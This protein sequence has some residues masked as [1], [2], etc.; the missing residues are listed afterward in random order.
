[1]V[2]TPLCTQ[3][4]VPSAN[5]VKVLQNQAQC[6]LEQASNTT[7]R[8]RNTYKVHL[9]ASFSLAEFLMRTS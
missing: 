9:E 3:R 8:S 4:N 6:A 5:R 1:M 2:Y 7:L